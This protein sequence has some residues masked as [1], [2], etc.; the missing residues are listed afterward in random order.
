[1]KRMILML[2]GMAVALV[3]L[4]ARLSGF[5]VQQSGMAALEWVRGAGLV[6]VLLFIAVYVLSSLCLVPCLTLNVAAGVL[7]GLPLGSAIVLPA[8]LAA[9]MAEFIFGRWLARDWVASR[10]ARIRSLSALDSALETAGL[11]VVLLMRVSPI[12]PFAML[13]Y[14]LGVTRLRFRDF[15]IASL[16][17]T[18]PG[19]LL[20]VVVGS[21]LGGAREV[22][23][24]SA[25]SAWQH[26]LL[27]LGLI[28]LAGAVWLLVRTARQQ[29]NRLM[30]EGCRSSKN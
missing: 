16:I 22:I 24:G 10:T 18:L 12:S 7:W 28:P 15:V 8:N 2:L 17:G 21:A 25:R 23:S 6:G 13:N 19:T 14:A 1:M 4:L 20:Y 26:Q 5:S 3:L 29:L 11:K 30:G 9:A 27:F